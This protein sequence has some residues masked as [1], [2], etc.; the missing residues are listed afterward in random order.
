MNPVNPKKL[1]LSKWTAA[2]PAGR[3]KHF[4]LT[5]VKEDE[6]GLPQQC[7]L[8]A[9]VTRKERIVHWRDLKSSDHWKMGWL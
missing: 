3:A 5:E 1:L 7:V 8:E 9:V 4:I 6:L 2:Q